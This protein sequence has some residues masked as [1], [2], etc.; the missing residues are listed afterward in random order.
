MVFLVILL[1]TFGFQLVL[2]W[3]IVIVISFAVCGVIGKTKKISFWQPFLAVATLWLGMAL[4]K[5]DPNGHV[6]AGRIAVMF[7]VK[8][9][10]AV[11]AITVV[12]GGL[13]AGISG[14]CGHYFRIAMV[15]P[16]TKA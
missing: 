14:L 11:L 4:Y 9:W 7:G 3:W 12:L 5:S 13:I 8:V 10:Y 15:V 1:L 2:P 6:L 16:K